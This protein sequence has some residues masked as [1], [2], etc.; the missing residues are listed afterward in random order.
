MEMKEEF[1]PKRE[2][3][4]GMENILNGRVRGGKVSSGQSPLH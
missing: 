3:K 2:I 1:S 4:T